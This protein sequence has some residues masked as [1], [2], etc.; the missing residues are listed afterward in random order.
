MTIPSIAGSVDRFAREAITVV[1]ASLAR[2][3]FGNGGRGDGHWGTQ[4]LGRGKRT[5]ISLLGIR[6]VKIVSGLDSG[7]VGMMAVQL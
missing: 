6:A 3:R 7:P 1:V 5:A 4:V 2:R